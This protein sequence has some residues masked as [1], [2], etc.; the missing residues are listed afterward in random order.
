MGRYHQHVASLQAIWYVVHM[1]G[2]FLLRVPL[3][4]FQRESTRQTA[5]VGLPLPLTKTPPI[6]PEGANAF[7]G[8]GSISSASRLPSLKANST[9]DTEVLEVAA[10]HNAWICMLPESIAKPMEKVVARMDMQ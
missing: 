6:Q 9:L 5:I 7:R 2:V 10:S 3:V 1:G 8:V 4:W